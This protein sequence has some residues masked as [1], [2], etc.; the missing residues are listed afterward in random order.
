MRHPFCFKNSA[1]FLM[2]YSI[3]KSF[4]FYLCFICLFLLVQFSGYWFYNKE[5]KLRCKLTKEKNLAKEFL[6]QHQLLNEYVNVTQRESTAL[7]LSNENPLAVTLS[8]LMNAFYLKTKKST[9]LHATNIYQ[10]KPLDIHEKDLVSAL[11]LMEGTRSKLFDHAPHKKV[12]RFFVKRSTK[13][14]DRFEVEIELAIMEP[15]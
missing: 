6:R 14:A 12:S 11:E 3:K 2:P 10:T 9:F 15:R 8:S 4:L 1:V 5:V 13:Q 7:F